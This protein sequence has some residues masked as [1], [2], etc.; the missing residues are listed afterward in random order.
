MLKVDKDCSNPNQS[1][2]NIIQ[3][4]TFIVI[5]TKYLFVFTWIVND[6]VLS[7]DSSISYIFL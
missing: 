2:V 1:D 3:P 5:Y 6:L 4:V 7:A